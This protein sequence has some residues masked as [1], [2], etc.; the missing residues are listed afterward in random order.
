MIRAIMRLKTG[1]ASG[2]D[3]MTN[4]VWM[5]QTNNGL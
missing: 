5:F 4:E 2:E 1:K 3:D